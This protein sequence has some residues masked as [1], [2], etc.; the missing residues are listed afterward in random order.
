MMGRKV[1]TMCHC[2][3]PDY[4]R[5]VLHALGECVGI[6]DYLILPH[7]EPASEEVRAEIEAIDFAECL[8]TFN[9][10]RLGVNR[11]TENALLDG[12]AFGDFVIHVEDD[13]VLAPDALLFYESMRRAI[14]EG[15]SGVLGDL[16]QPSA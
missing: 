15:P 12:F 1:I 10:S 14:S 2:L 3:R 8:P 5:R 4:S 7:V 9:A 6:A 13:I 11:N 16:L